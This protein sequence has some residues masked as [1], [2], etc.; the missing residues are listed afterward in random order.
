MDLKFYPRSSYKN[1]YDHITSRQQ[2]KILLDTWI[3]NQKPNII[4]ELNQLLQDT[5]SKPVID[6]LV[7]DID[8]KSHIISR[9]DIIK[10]AIEFGE[11]LKEG[12]IPRG[13]VTFKDGKQFQSRIT[14]YCDISFWKDKTGY[15]I[16]VIRKK[17]NEI[18]AFSKNDPHIPPVSYLY[19]NKETR[20]P[21][22]DKN[23]LL[24]EKIELL[25]DVNDGDFIYNDKDELWS[26]KKE[27]LMEQ[28]KI[29]Q[30]KS[31]GRKRNS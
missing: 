5:N 25:R 18:S 20:I 26:T 3:Q 31:G 27:R 24:E 22:I 13:T 23:Y 28:V 2:I 11:M 17:N 8:N 19:D 10:I 7:S 16:D 4:N 21:I 30:K 14:A 15:I 9:D 29:L 12:E 6:I 1:K